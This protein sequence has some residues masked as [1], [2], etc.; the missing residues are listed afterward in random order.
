VN[1]DPTQ[2][3]EIRKTHPCLIISPDEMNR[4]IST[5]IVAPMTTQGPRLSHPYQPQVSS[6]KR[7]NRTGPNPHR[8]QNTTGQTAGEDRQEHSRSHA[9]GVAGDVCGVGA[10]LA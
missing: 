3:H 2:G 7:Q 10:E 4:H 5:V 9:G 6:K 8:G 1:L